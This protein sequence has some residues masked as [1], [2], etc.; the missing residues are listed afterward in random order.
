MVAFYSVIYAFK[1]LVRKGVSAKTRWQFFIQ[2]MSYVFVLLIVWS[3][4]LLH[5]YVELYQIDNSISKDYALIENL[6]FYFM[7]GCGFFVTAVRIVD[8]FYRHIV[9]E[10]IREYFGV[11]TDDIENDEAKPLNSFLAESLN[12]ELINIILQGITK[13]S[14][15]GWSV[16]RDKELK[17]RKESQPNIKTKDIGDFKVRKLELD[18]I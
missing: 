12:V 13:F 16:I 17:R 8:P 11:V 18:R 14:E 9:K 6:S 3:I 10:T 2:H 1:R 15:P 5:N 4:Q 7:F